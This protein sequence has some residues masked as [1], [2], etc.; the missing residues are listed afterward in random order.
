MPHSLN[1]AVLRA[2]TVSF[3]GHSV[4]LPTPDKHTAKWVQ[5]MIKL[6]VAGMVAISLPV[7]KQQSY[8]SYFLQT[9]IVA[10]KDTFTNLN[11]LQV[12]D[13]IIRMSCI[14]NFPDVCGSAMCL[15]QLSF[16]HLQYHPSMQFPLTCIATDLPALYISLT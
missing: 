11:N 8:N 6:N 9:V 12:I 13:T 2:C 3:C 5:Y 10:L 4:V 14:N 1:S 7:C 15:R 16:L